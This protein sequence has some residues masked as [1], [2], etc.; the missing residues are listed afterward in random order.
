MPAETFDVGVAGKLVVAG[1]DRCVADNHGNNA[2]H[3]AAVSG[4]AEA[5]SHM[6][7]LEL[8]AM[9]DPIDEDVLLAVRALRLLSECFECNF[10]EC[11]VYTHR[12]NK[13]C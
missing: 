8:G 7:G 13:R 5:V 9:K 11:A 10:T 2:F 12:E 3:L 6:L 1:A 4:C